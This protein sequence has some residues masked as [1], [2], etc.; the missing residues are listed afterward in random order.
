VFVRQRVLFVCLPSCLL[1]MLYTCWSVVEHNFNPSTWEAEAGRFLSSN[2]S[3]LSFR[4]ARATQKNPVSEKT[5]QTNKQS[6]TPML[7]F[8]CRTDLVFLTVSISIVGSFS[9][10]SLCNRFIWLY[11]IIFPIFIINRFSSFLEATE[12]I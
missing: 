11:L 8:C 10:I 9:Y 3:T 7:N 12:F 5:K 2:W 6:F 4:T 1:K